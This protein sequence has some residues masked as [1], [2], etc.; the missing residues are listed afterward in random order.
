ML[1]E[2]PKHIH[3][4]GV[5][6]VGM[7]ALAQAAL[8]RGI[9]VSGS[10][11][12]AQADSNPAV[13][14]LLKEGAVIF[15]F[16]ARE[17]LAPSVEMVVASAAVPEDNPELQEAYRRGL[18]VL[19][20]AAFLGALMDDH[21]GPTLAVAGTHGKTTTTAMIGVMLQQAGKD[22]T[23]FVGAEVPQLGGNAR[24]GAP[25]APFVTEAC[26]AYGSFLHLHPHYAVITN[27][28]ADHLDY[29]QTSE[30]VVSSFRNFAAQIRSAEG[31]L[32]VC[33]DDPGV[34]Q[35]L[36]TF[37]PSCALY[38]YSLNDVKILEE[39]QH[40][41][42]LWNHGGRELTITLS[43]PGRHNLLNA[44]AAALAG[45]LFGLTETQIAQGLAAFTGV[46]RRQEPIGTV[47]LPNGTIQIIDDYA[48]HPTEIHATLAAQ[49][50]A[51]PHS[52]LLVVFQPHLYSR[53][54]DFLNEFAAALA[55]ADAV[56]V[57]DIYPARE[58][59]IP[60]VRTADIVHGVVRLK[61]SIPAIFLPNKTDAPKMLHALA[62][63]GDVVLFLGAGDIRDEAVS[64][65]HLLQKAGLAE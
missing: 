7:S 58:R 59:P 38:T 63:P 54:R 25:S 52:R 46:E 48:H 39:G 20:R 1:K 6:G 24:I 49:R 17:N 45:Q 15:D 37:H 51:H 2:L 56:I 32:I 33:R 40:T 61:P 21:P 34:Q 13:A 47:S 35:L 4:I 23:V 14:R 29:Y 22:P 30:N 42:F 36:K 26:E 41:R 12:H 31:A 64:F 10:D 43:L 55:E 8:S 27:I 18:P 44:L 9:K 19:T 65:F 53:T 11:P 5:A 16:H 50:Q 62:Q 57:T 28:E 60:G 3:F